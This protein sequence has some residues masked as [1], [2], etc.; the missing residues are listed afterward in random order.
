MNIKADLIDSDF[1]QPEFEVETRDDGTILMRQKGDLTGY[2]PTLADYLDKWA[3]QTPD[4]TWIA[5]R[6]AD[7]AWVRITYGD[8]RQ[9]A[10]HIGGALLALGL[11]P[12]RP[13]LILSEN[14]LEH[15]LLGAACFYVGIPYA[16]VSP[17]YSLVSKDHGKL[18]DIAAVL[19]PGAVFADK[20]SAFA[21]ALDAI[22]AEGRHVLAV[23]DAV[24]G[25]VLFEDLLNGDVDLAGGCPD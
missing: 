13:L 19:N 24:E 25:A 5:R 12:D 23:Q 14:S 7:G 10:R 3:D 8:A 15:A 22:A 4:Q 20:A 17:A 1:W 11:G 2:L 9:Q 21:P 18:R 16:P 6:G